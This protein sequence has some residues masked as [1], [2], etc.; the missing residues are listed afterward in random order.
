MEKELKQINAEYVGS[1][2][3]KIFTYDIPSIYYRFAEIKELLKSKNKLVV[4]NN[5]SKLRNVL[6]E[7]SDLENQNQL[8]SIYKEMVLVDFEELFSMEHDI[9]IRKIKESL[10]LNKR[11]KKFKINPNKWIRLRQSND[12]KELTLKHVYQ[13][14]DSRI[15]KVKEIELTV[16][17]IEEMNNFLE[18]IGIVRRNYQE[19][20]RHS[21]VYKDAEIEIDEWPYLEPYMEIECDNNNTIKELIDLLDLNKYEI[22]SLN[23]Q[24]LYKRKNINVLE[25]D[26]L[27]FDEKDRT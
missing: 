24:E 20:I 21:Y 27:R 17:S 6:D 12:K 11:I 9:I 16:D 26:E 19:K 5:I 8:E 3:Q 25:M 10:L 13:K 4:K 18:G 7:Y 2:N 23:T 22:V 14:N 15:Q 1:K